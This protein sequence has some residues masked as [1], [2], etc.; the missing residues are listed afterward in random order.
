MENVNG[1]RELWRKRRESIDGPQNAR[2]HS[3][4]IQPP[5]Q[6]R[7]G[8]NG[9]YRA[10]GFRRFRQ[11]RFRVIRINAFLFPDEYNGN[12]RQRHTEFTKLFRSGQVFS[13]KKKKRGGGK[14][15]NLRPKRMAKERLHAAKILIDPP[16]EIKFFLTVF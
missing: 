14:T 10:G 9:E 3:Q 16:A 2:R 11:A 5:G 4:R 1:Q 7:S 8:K 12:Y 6:D 13:L 15:G